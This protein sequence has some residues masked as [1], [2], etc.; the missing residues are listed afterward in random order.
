MVDGIPNTKFIIVKLL[1]MISKYSTR[2]T[3]YVGQTP[4]IGANYPCFKYLLL[5][6]KTVSG[7]T[8]ILYPLFY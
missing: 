5:I 6:F 2:F 8:S 7:V 4:Y 1:T 3:R